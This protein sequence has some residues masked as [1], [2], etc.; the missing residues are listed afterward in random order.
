[1]TRRGAARS[2][3]AQGNNTMN[4]D[5]AIQAVEL[6][7]I[8]QMDFSEIATRLCVAVAE[9]RRLVS[10]GRATVRN[11]PP[12]FLLPSYDLEA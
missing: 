7:T 12:A 11:G 1:M 5:I 6:R 3:I 9:V 8:Y 10:S 2:H 4:T